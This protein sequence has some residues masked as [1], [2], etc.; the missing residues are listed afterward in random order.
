MQRPPSK[1]GQTAPDVA[2]GVDKPGRRQSK[3]YHNKRLEEKRRKAVES[4]PAAAVPSRN[5]VGIHR[6][7]EERRKLLPVTAL[8]RCDK[9]LSF[10]LPL[11]LIDLIKSTDPVDHVEC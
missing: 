10:A 5:T 9:L 8:S 2:I 1:R 4:P 11:V 6:A 3:H 7:R